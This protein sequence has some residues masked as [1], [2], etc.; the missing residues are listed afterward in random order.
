M[1]NFLW[2]S[3]E[4]SALPI[5]HTT[6]VRHRRGI[7]PWEM[8]ASCDRSEENLSRIS[9][10]YLVIVYL[11]LSSLHRES[12]AVA[13]VPQVPPERNM[14]SE[15]SNTA[16]SPTQHADIGWSVVTCS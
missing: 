13:R 9:E 16:Q 4:A 8:A 14:S 15:R 6:E 1:S 3:V 10:T 11:V 5:G 7:P 12:Q 2:R